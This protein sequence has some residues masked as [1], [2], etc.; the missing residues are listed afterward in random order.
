MDKQAILDLLH[1]IATDPY[2][3]D[4]LIADPVGV[5]GA[6]GIKITANDIPPGGITLP[7]NEVSTDRRMGPSNELELPIWGRGLEIGRLVIALPRDARAVEI[8]VD[9]RALALTLVDQLGAVLAASA[10]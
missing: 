1:K 10:T 3:R 8:P 5:M 9:D 6:A 4:Q 2:F 7:S